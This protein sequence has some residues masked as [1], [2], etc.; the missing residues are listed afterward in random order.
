MGTNAIEASC[1]FAS[2]ADIFF[3]E[4]LGRRYISVLECIQRFLLETKKCFE[5][6]TYVS[7]SIYREEGTTHIEAKIYYTLIFIT[8]I[9]Y[10]Y[11]VCLVRN[12]RY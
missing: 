9:Y 7:V 1:W 3:K 12:N 8:V 5:W 11:V 2:M 6:R 10:I 4:K